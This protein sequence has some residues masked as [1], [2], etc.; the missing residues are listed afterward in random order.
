MDS[1]T[2]KVLMI[3]SIL[4][5]GI[6]LWKLTSKPAS[7]DKLAGGTIS[8]TIGEQG[9]SRSVGREVGSIANF[10]E[11]Q[12]AVPATVTVKNTSV[13]IGSSEL[14]PYSFLV[15]VY[16]AAPG[17]TI[18]V[19]PMPLSPISFAKGEQKVLSYPFNAPFGCSTLGGTAT[20]TAQ[21]L[22]GT[23]NMTNILTSDILGTI[24]LPITIASVGITPQG[25][26]QW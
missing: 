17:V 1:K 2:K 8:L 22:K 23:T 16:I 6:L 10:T 9:A 20:A 12:Q 26:I 4:V 3:G 19:T 24:T 18:P 25:V 14:A 13:Y 11:G 15:L 7:A 21:L 5:G